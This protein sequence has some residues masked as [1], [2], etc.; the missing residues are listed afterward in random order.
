MYKTRYL[1][2]VALAIFSL[3]FWSHSFAQSNEWVEGNVQC[4]YAATG[5][6]TFEASWLIGHQVVS[7]DYDGYL[8]QIADLLV[9]RSDGRIALV[10]L[11]DTPGAGL[12][13]IAVPFSALVRTGENT[14]ELSFAG[15]DVPLANPEHQYYNELGDRYAQFLARNRGTIGLT[16]ISAAIDPLWADSVY[17]FYGLTP[18][19]TEG[20]TPHPDIVS[21]RETKM[22]GAE[23]QSSD[24]TKIGRIDDLVIDYPDGRIAFVVLD[25]VPGRKGAMVAVPF[26]EL[27]MNGNA[28]VFNIG[29]DQLA[30]APAFVFS[31]LNN[32]RKAEEIY[33]FFGVTPYWTEPAPTSMGPSTYESSN[34]E[35]EEHSMPSS[36]Y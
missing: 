31:D 5:W 15:L 13:R 1:F 28:Y 12:E 9:D 19:W 24:G 33:F 34:S 4:G 30:G 20:K 7:P 32:E 29:A 25:D 3:M 18:Y 6:D 21:Y 2:I 16:T 17:E 14:F 23:A 10:I 8:G 27:P 22:L 35:M 11:S 36:E 26:G